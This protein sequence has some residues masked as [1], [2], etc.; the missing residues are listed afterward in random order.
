MTNDN[1]D[2]GH[3]QCVQIKLLEF[4]ILVEILHILRRSTPV[5][6]T[7]SESMYGLVGNGAVNCHIPPMHQ[8][9]P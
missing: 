7:G 9:R 3:A 6:G 1:P 5:G 4:G 8:R 2:N